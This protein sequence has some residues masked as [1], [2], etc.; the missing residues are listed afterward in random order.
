VPPAA[1]GASHNVMGGPPAGSIFFPHWNR[2]ERLH[3]FEQ[4]ARAAA[5]LN[6]PNIL[7][8]YDIGTQQQPQGVTCRVSCGDHTAAGTQGHSR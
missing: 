6:H 2:R 5:A 4:E 8:L 3:R 7:A 1:P